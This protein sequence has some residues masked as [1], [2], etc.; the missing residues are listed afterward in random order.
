MKK[1]SI[2]FF[3]LLPLPLFAADFALAGKTFQDIITYITTDLV[4]PLLYALEALAFLVFSYGVIRFVIKA[5]NEAEL[6]A[7]KEYMIGG[8]LA[9]F[10][11]ISLSSILGIIY[12]D[13]GF[14][15]SF[16]FDYRPFLKQETTTDVSSKK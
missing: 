2:L 9:L 4:F 11:L 14:K 3:V 15:N 16:R 6:K 5:D 10:V 7:G 8:I 13:L 12:N 1:Y